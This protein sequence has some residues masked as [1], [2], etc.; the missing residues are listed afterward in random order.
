MPVGV[1]GILY[2]AYFRRLP[3]YGEKRYGLHDPSVASG[4]I[5]TTGRIKIPVFT[6][7]IKNGFFGSV[8]MLRNFGS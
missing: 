7:P 3:A 2:P 5:R 8:E 1:T 4:R 6:N